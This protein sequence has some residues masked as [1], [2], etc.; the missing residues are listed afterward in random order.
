MENHS[1]IGYRTR[2]ISCQPGHIRHP[3]LQIDELGRALVNLCTVVPGG[4]VCFFPSYDYE[5]RVH[6]HWSKTGILER[7]ARK[8]QVSVLFD[9]FW[10]YK[11]LP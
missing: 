9:A 4:V 7:I 11:M 3:F 6:A 10:A 2:G 8:K 5:K 1:E